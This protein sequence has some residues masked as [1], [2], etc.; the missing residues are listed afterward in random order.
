MQD[1]IK[2][3]FY[4]VDNISLLL[5]A[6]GLDKCKNAI[7]QTKSFQHASMSFTID[8][9]EVYFFPQSIS[10]GE[11]LVIDADL[12]YYLPYSIRYKSRELFDK[13]L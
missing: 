4:N 2:L 10:V 1:K 13:I 9:V 6:I 5:E 12:H 8:D 11:V 3:R 7:A